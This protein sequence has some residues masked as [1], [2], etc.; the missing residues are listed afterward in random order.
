MIVKLKAYGM[1]NQSLAFMRPMSIYIIA[2]KGWQFWAKQ[3][4][5]CMNLV[6]GVPQGL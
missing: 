1:S 3:T 4:T 6:K 5:E 2:S